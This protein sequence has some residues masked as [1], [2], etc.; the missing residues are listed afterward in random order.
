MV[1]PAG[2]GGPGTAARRTSIRASLVTLTAAAIAGALIAVALAALSS[3]SSTGAA[4]GRP[5]RLGRRAGRSRRSPRSQPADVRLRRRDR[6]A[7]AFDGRR[8]RPGG[9]RRADHDPLVLLRLGDPGRGLRTLLRQWN[10]AGLHPLQQ[11][12]GRSSARHLAADRD[13]RCSSRGPATI[14]PAAGAPTA[15]RLDLQAIVVHRARPCTW[16]SGTRTQGFSSSTS[17]ICR[18]SAPSRW[19]RRSRSSPRPRARSTRSRRTPGSSA[20]RP[21]PTGAEATPTRARST[22]SC[23]RISTTSMRRRTS[24]RGPERSA[25]SGT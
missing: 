22:S 23:P 3:P 16:R 5:G 8:S 17:P 14:G 19:R 25:A 6:A 1:S 11:P 12:A 15:G 13:P 18:S 2:R 21:R 10:P 24:I 7:P 4:D 20:R 9:E